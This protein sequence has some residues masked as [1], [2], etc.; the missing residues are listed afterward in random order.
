[1]T[2]EKRTFLPYSRGI[3]P[4]RLRIGNLAIDFYN[5]TI[6]RETERF[7][8]QKTTSQ[9]EYEK[10]LEEWAGK[11]QRD[12][13]CSLNFAVTEEWS[14][15]AGLLDLFNADGASQKTFRAVIEGQ[16]ARRF[17]V[18]EPIRFFNEAVYSQEG[19]REWIRNKLTIAANGRLKKGGIGWKPPQI[20]VCTGVQLINRGAVRYGVSSGYSIGGGVNVDAGLVTM[21]IPSG[22]SLVN[23]DV[24]KASNSQVENSYDYKDER[25]WAAQWFQLDVKFRQRGPGDEEKPMVVTLKEVEDL[26]HGVRKFQQYSTAQDEV[27]GDEWVDVA[28]II[29]LHSPD[30]KEKEQLDQSEADRL[31]EKSDLEFDERPYADAMD[32]ID[33][34]MYEK[35]CKY[36]ETLDA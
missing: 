6:G 30:V 24:G 22:Q 9:D 18:E 21:G 20:W 29:G 1:M 5:P 8:F 16:G 32:G 11:P 15:K 13:Q 35:Y 12:R 23:V 3:D 28:E 34:T 17:E 7:K 36:L 14:V 33:W 27:D 10:V 2:G 19:V 26:K 31:G 4:T 25:V